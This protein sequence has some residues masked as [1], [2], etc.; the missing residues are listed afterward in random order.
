MSARDE[1][2]I[3][4]NDTEHVLAVTA[5]VDLGLDLRWT[6]LGAGRV[7]LLDGHHGPTLLEATA[8][9]SGPYWMRRIEDE[10]KR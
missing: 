6:P 9:T 8:M 1:T 4:G 3:I 5:P 2:W 7:R 10:R